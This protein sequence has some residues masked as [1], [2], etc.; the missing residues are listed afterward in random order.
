MR[1]ELVAR[2]GHDFPAEA[3]HDVERELENLALL[4]GGNAVRKGR[5]EA[6]SIGNLRRSAVAMHGNL[7]RCL[8][9]R[10]VPHERSRVTDPDRFLL[11][12]RERVTVEREREEIIEPVAPVKNKG[13]RHGVSS[14]GVAG[15]CVR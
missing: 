11:L 15:I 8:V 12:P 1:G 7:D 3:A 4:T 13:V 5:I 10:G 14:K 2:V 6:E 9:R